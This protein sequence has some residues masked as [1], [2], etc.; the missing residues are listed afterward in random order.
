MQFITFSVFVWA[1]VCETEHV[2]NSTRFLLQ[3]FFF[4][5][6]G[7]CSANHFLRHTPHEYKCAIHECENIDHS[8]KWLP[9]KKDEKHNN[10]MELPIVCYVSNVQ[11][12]NICWC[13]MRAPLPWCM[14]LDSASSWNMI[15]LGY[16]INL[17]SFGRNKGN[18]SAKL[19]WM[20]VH[21]NI[22]LH[23][24]TRLVCFDSLTKSKGKTTANKQKKTTTS[25]LKDKYE[26]Q[27]CICLDGM[28]KWKYILFSHVC[29]ACINS[30]IVIFA[31]PLLVANYACERFI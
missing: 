26:T 28:W 22:V 12:S 24:Y 19:L 31:G 3:L 27:I 4:C 18:D 29:D 7:F 5:G 21:N 30:S 8:Q 2:L 23:T 10:R 20:L 1:G 25:N 17:N 6:C 9:C 16:C 15:S 14:Q 11:D 13:M